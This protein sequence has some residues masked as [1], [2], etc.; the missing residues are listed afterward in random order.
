VAYNDPS[1][2]TVVYNNTTGVMVTYNN[3]ADLTVVYNGSTGSQ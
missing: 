3:P 2:L 1:D